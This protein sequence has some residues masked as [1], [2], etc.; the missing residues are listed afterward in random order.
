MGAEGNSADVVVML[1]KAAGN[2]VA[3]EL[4]GTEN[5]VRLTHPPLSAN[6]SSDRSLWWLSAGLCGL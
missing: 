2:R 4:D 3:L 1:A 6:T 5:G